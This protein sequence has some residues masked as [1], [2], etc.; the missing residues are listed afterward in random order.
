MT[1][2][3]QKAM[4]LAAIEEGAATSQDVVDVTGLSRKK[5]AVYLGRLYGLGVLK[6]K[7]LRRKIAGHPEYF[8]EVA[9]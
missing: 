4:V 9:R 5:A 8:Y 3:Q 2:I 1:H 7:P 6:R